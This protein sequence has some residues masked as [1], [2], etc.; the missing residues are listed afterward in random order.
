[1]VASGRPHRRVDRAQLAF[2]SPSLRGSGRFALAVLAAWREA[3]GFNPL[4]CGAVVASWTRPPTRRL[5]SRCFNPLHC[6]AVV[7]SEARVQIRQKIQKFQSPSLRGS[8]RFALKPKSAHGRKRSF[9][10][11]HCGAVVASGRPPRPPDRPR[12]VSIPFIAGQW[13]LRVCDPAGG[14]FDH[15]V[16][17]PFIAG[18]WSLLSAP[19]AGP[20]GGP[21][22]IPFIA[23]QWSLRVSRMRRR[24]SSVLFQSPSLRG[25]G[26]FQRAA[27]DLARAQ[28]RFNPLHCGAVVASD[29][30]GVRLSLA[31]GG[32]NPLHCGAVVASVDILLASALIKRFQSP[33][34]RGSG[35]FNL[36]DRPS[37]TNLI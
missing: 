19:G 25:S 4:H 2:Q 21:V 17:I 37:L 10:P 12:H 31:W 35:R 9:N 28:E 33:S 8:G 14:R 24:S 20:L 36:T 15:H 5:G 6:G 3:A 7:A 27:A 1:M 23:G 22:S 18:Q 30:H 29:L 13:S 16:S 32:F 34:L 11:L 26:R